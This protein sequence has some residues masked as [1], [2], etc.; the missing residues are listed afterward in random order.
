M[1]AEF[2]SNQGATPPAASSKK[3][4]TLLDVS[5]LKR[6]VS[7]L[8]EC[9]LPVLHDSGIGRSIMFPYSILYP[10]NTPDVRNP[11]PNLKSGGKYSP[12]F[13]SFMPLPYSEKIYI[14]KSSEIQT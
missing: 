5:L 14:M 3:C 4:D 7:G 8:S 6:T 1:S 10:E 11:G 9:V 2:C 13:F 12:D